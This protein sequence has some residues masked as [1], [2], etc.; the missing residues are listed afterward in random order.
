MAPKRHSISDN[1][2]HNE[3]NDVHQSMELP[4][5]DDWIWSKRHR[6]Q[7]VMLSDSSY[8]KGNWNILIIIT[9]V[10]C[11]CECVHISCHLITLANGNLQY[12]YSILLNVTAT[13]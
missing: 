2:E 12:A 5:S 9:S 8:R 6:S 3:H 4:Y 10:Y 11:E 1:M 7:E 13:N